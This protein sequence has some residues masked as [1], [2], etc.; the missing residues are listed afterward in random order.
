MG[1]GVEEVEE[2]EKG[3]EPQRAVLPVKRNPK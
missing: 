1:R 3:R 2:T